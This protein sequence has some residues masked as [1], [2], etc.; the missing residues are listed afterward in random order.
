MRRRG[1]RT[2]RSGEDE[3]A[4]LA[5]A[6]HRAAH[7]IPDRRH[8]LPLV[9]QHRR[10]GCQNLARVGFEDRPLGRIVE[11][12]GGRGA[13]FSGGCLPDA[14]W[15]LDR[16]GRQFGHKAVEF[17]V[18]NPPRVGHSGTLFPAHTLPYCHSIRYC[19]DDSGSW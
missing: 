19:F 3:P 2:G 4:R 10:R 6:I 15:P 9:D 14:S 11:I 1:R 5:T 7:H 8:F 13:L 17:V 18:D 12:P 16:H